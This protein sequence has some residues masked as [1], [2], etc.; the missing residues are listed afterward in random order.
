MHTKVLSNRVF[1]HKDRIYLINDDCFDKSYD[2]F[3][4]TLPGGVDL[5]LSDPPFGIADKG[6]VT[7][8]HGKIYSNKQAW[9]SEFKDEF[10]ESEYDSLIRSF[11][12]RAFSFLKDGGSLVSFIDRRYSGKFADICEESGFIYKGEITFVKN[13]FVPKVRAFSFGSATERAVWL[14]KPNSGRTPKGNKVAKTK[15]LIF[16]NKKAQKNLRHACGALDIKSYHNTASSNVFFYNIGR[17][18]TGHPCEKY[19]AQL[20]PIIEHLT[21]EDS[22]ILDFFGGGFNCALVSHELK[23]RFVGF[24]LDKKWQI[25]A[26]KLLLDLDK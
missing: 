17:K 15:P 11:S 3:L 16:N 18:R 22:W 1:N 8:A 26:K 4:Q 12:E 13:N 24:E 14:I 7:K 10:T 6:K 9:G 23:R 2:T 19:T 21:N 5:V 25:N 20:K